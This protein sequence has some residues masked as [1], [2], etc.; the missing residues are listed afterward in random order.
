M[1]RFLEKD[2]IRWRDHPLRKPL[3]LQGARQVGKTYL[4]EHF[5]RQHF[6]QYVRLNFENKEKLG[7]LF[8]DLSAAALIERLSLFYGEKLIPGKALIFFDEAQL[9]PRALTSLKYFAEEAPEYHVIAAGSLLGVQV[10]KP[11]SFPV[12]K[13]DFLTLRPFSFGEYLIASGKELLWEKVSQPDNYETTVRDFHDTLLDAFRWYMFLGG[14][15]EV[16]QVYF[17]YRDVKLAR[18]VQRSILLSYQNDFSKYTD[19]E[20]ATKLSQVWRSIPQQ[21]ARENKKFKFGEVRRKARAATFDTTLDWLRNAGLIHSIPFLSNAKIPLEAYADLSKF[22]VYLFDTG[23]LG[24]MLDLQ[25]AEVLQPDRLFREYNGAFTENVVA[26]ELIAAGFNRLYYWQSRGIAEVDFVFRTE[27]GIL[28]LEV[29]SGSGTDT[30]S[31]RSY[32]QKYD[33]PHLYR[34]SPRNLRTDGDFTNLPLYLM[35]RFRPL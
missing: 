29:K 33:P 26:Q 28:P 19:S 10:G 31:I 18:D 8:R 5:A 32:A 15:P 2:L 9:E 27:A 11:S 21:L 24:A 25:S 22:K 16:L 3:V 14:M 6:P 23:L 35:S 12:G 13:V 7:D 17:Q 34:A 30:K 1:D 20:G 4:V